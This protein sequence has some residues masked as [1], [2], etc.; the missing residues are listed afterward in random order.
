M[1]DE[2]KNNSIN[3]H[4]KHEKTHRKMVCIS[5]EFRYA[6]WE[7]SDSDLSM[8]RSYLVGLTVTAWN[9][10]GKC[11][12]AIDRLGCIRHCPHLLNPPL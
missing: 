11:F 9:I 3:D 5:H 6:W 10:V 4:Y 1:T 2:N 8:P 7:I 12:S